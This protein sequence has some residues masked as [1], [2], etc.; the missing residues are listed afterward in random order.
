M[1]GVLVVLYVVEFGHS[2]FESVLLIQHELFNHRQLYDPMVQPHSS[3]ENSC[4]GQCI[5]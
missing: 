5:I 4:V 3:P 1:E 2:A